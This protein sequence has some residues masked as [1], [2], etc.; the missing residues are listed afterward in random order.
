MILNCVICGKQFSRCGKQ[1][2][3]AKT[4][5]KKCMGEYFKAQPN[6]FCT[7][8]GKHFHL[9]ESAKTKYNRNHGYF[10]SIKCHA[11]Y[12]K[13]ALKGE[14]NHQYGL[15][16][17][18]NSSFKGFILDNINGNNIDKLIYCP[19]HPYKDK[20]SRVL[21]HRL[22]VEC[23]YIKFNPEWFE[24][25]GG[26]IVLKRNAIIH[27]IDFNH[28]NNNVNNLMIVNKSQHATIHNKHNIIIRDKKSRIAEVVKEDESLA[29]N[30]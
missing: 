1:A 2:L 23:N 16:G 29:N 28:N 15:K 20:N 18:K 17:Y 12:K 11:E 8:C 27:H 7:Q 22:I 5:S 21:L 24:N 14:G 4:C 13:E 9:K 19:N 25:K 3:K 26:Y 10:C 6:T 30:N